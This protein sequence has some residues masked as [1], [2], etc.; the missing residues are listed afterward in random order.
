MGIVNLP[1]H[2]ELEWIDQPLYNVTF[3]LQVAVYS[4]YQDAAQEWHLR[5]EM[6]VMCKVVA[7]INEKREP[8][9]LI[10]GSRYVS[11]AICQVQEQIDGKNIGWNLEEWKPRRVYHDQLG[12]VRVKLPTLLRGR[13]NQHEARLR[14]L[15][16][17]A[18]D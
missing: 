18:M 17:L 14:R 6:R 1:L 5:V 13:I 2:R 9:N 8:L 10:I 3:P 11:S 12:F 7:V 4:P 15:R 16:A